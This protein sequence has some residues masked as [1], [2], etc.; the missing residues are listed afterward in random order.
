MTAIVRVNCNAGNRNNPGLTALSREL[1]IADDQL[2]KIR[3]KV[4]KGQ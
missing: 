2:L 1:S 4:I 3:G